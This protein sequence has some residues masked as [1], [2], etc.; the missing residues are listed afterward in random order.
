MRP[1][2]TAGVV[3]RGVSALAGGALKL[4]QMIV[5]ESIWS[6][7]ATVAFHIGASLLKSN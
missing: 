3:F 1:I 5:A 2:V 6:P 7:C 4:G